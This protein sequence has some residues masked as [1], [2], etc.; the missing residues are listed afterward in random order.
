V[1]VCPNCG[2]HN[3][4]RAKFCL[5]C[6]SPLGRTDSSDGDET[7]VEAAGH[8]FDHPPEPV[9]IRRFLE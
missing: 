7:L 4:E 8:L 5:N 3:P 2:E 1:A 9:W 6:A